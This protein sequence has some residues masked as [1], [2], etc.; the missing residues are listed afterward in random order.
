MSM[1]DI[2]LILAIWISKLVNQGV[3][4][5]ISMT[6]FVQHLGSLTSSTVESSANEKRILEEWAR[7]VQT[8]QV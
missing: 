1:C 5:V 4:S 8:R 6:S 2:Q 7:S 3:V